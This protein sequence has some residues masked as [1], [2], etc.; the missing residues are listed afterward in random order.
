MPR[1]QQNDKSDEMTKSGRVR[2]ISFTYDEDPDLLDLANENVILKEAKSARP[3]LRDLFKDAL[4][5]DNTRLKN[6]LQVAV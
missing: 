4:K 6:K 1:K 5:K 3:V 2:S